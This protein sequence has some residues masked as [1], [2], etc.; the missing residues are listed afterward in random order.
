MGATRHH[1]TL[2]NSDRQSSPP[3][4]KKER[5]TSGTHPALSLTRRPVQVI[6]RLSCRASQLGSNSQP[7][8]NHVQQQQQDWLTLGA[9]PCR[10]HHSATH[11]GHCRQSISP[12][13]H[14]SSA[15]QETRRMETSSRLQG[16]TPSRW[17]SRMCLECLGKRVRS[18][19]YRQPLDRCRCR[20]KCTGGNQGESFSSFSVGHD[21]RRRVKFSC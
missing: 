6:I 20:K 7:C 13:A 9:D 4:S 5:M 1:T 14:R 3:A 11:L 18:I 16:S 17:F 19:G 8:S 2:R 10:S 15:R 12:H 21:Q